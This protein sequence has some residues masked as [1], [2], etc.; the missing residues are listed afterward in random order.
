MEQIKAYPAGFHRYTPSAVVQLTCQKPS[1]LDRGPVSA[2]F[3]DK[4]EVEAE[5]IICR[6]L[7][8][9]AYRLDA[10]QKAQREHAFGDLSQ[11]VRRIA[12]IAKQLGL[13]EVSLSATHMAD[14]ALAQDG[15]AVNAIAARL[16]RAFD[17]AVTE[18]W[19]YLG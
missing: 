13:T 14:A 7:E 18:V 10:V 15:I 3:A 9:I 6:V 5:E 19:H 16:E 2:M 12:Q 1:A 17:H 4:G 8:D 11:P